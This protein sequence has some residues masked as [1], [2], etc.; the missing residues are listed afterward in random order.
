MSKLKVVYFYDALCGW[1]YGFSPVMQRVYEEYR[2]SL[3]FSVVSGGMIVGER[4][5]PVGEVAGYIAWGYKEV[6][7]T[8]GVKFGERFLDGILKPGTALFSS[9]PAALALSAHRDRFPETSME[10]ASTLQKAVYF[11]GI[12]SGVLKD[13]IPYAEQFGWDGQ[14]F[15]QKMESEEM[16]QTALGDFAI[17]Q[18]WQVQ[19]FPTVF[20]LSEDTAYMLTNGYI[21][22]ETIKD[23]LERAISQVEEN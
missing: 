16:Q 9:I 3:D 17:T 5:G 23:R 18:E 2:D 20:L 19:G 15:I 13:F 8:T 6:E 11:D 22:Y 7:S 12:R 10:F 21:P 1:C 4:E 14:E